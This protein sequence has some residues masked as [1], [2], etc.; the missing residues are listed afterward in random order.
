MG[1]RAYDLPPITTR[2]RRPSFDLN[3]QRQV[4][5]LIPQ[6]PVMS[7]RGPSL[8][9]GDMPDAQQPEGLF[10][11]EDMSGARSRGLMGFG[12]SLLGD[13][14]WH[15]KYGGPTLGSSIGR[16]GQAGLQAFDAAKANSLATRQQA[17]Q[18]RDAERLSKSR[19]MIAGKYPIT[20]GMTSE[21]TI[22]TL[23]RMF[24]EFSAAGDH[25]MSGKIGEVLKSYGGN[26]A[27]AKTPQYE[28]FGGYKQMID[29]ATGQPT[30]PRIPLTV[31]PRDTSAPLSA[32]EQLHEQ[33]MTARA[34]ALNS[35]WIRETARIAQAS[36]QFGTL[37]ANVDEAKGGNPLAQMS[38]VFS[39]MKTL[40]PTSVVRESEYATAEN[41]RG[42][43]ETIRNLWN[44]VKDGARLTPEQID[45]MVVSG[46]NS[47]KTWKRKQS[48][49]AKTYTARAKRRGVDP[50]DV[51]SDYFDGMGLDDAPGSPTSVGGPSAAPAN[52]AAPHF[53][54]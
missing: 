22:A 36:E 27:G 23:E 42:V 18:M 2:A 40:D 19:A 7:P 15:P 24:A 43:P 21:Q 1:A 17:T 16:A 30:G 3:L 35:A 13:S 12:L 38:M 49:F 28:D 54:F 48:S 32:A 44:R 9:P 47:A 46:R 31:K 10:T 45:N 5:N 34:N 52:P 14:G 33:R 53:N 39:F 41:A 8:Q 20:P 51:I 11:P 25:E 37:M 6:M 29:P 50:D 4:Q 26:R